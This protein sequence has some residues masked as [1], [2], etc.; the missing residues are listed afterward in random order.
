MKIGLVQ[1]VAEPGDLSAN[2]RRVVEGCRA[3][4]DAG[5]E[6]IA[7]PAWA[8]DGVLPGGL[9][10][11]S[12]FLLQAQ[13]ALRALAAEV[14]LPLILPCHAAPPHAGRAEPSLFLLHEGAVHK[15]ENRSVLPWKGHALYLHVG[16]DWTPPEQG[17]TC[18]CCLHWPTSAWLPGRPAALRTAAAHAADSLGVPVLIAQALG[19]SGGRLMPGGS[20]AAAPR[21]GVMQLPL[22]APTERVWHAGA[23]Y[24]AAPEAE[25]GVELLGAV[26]FYLHSLL[27]QSG[28]AGF[29]IDATGKRAAFAAALAAS[30]VGARRVTALVP[31]DSA[32]PLPFAA[33]TLSLPPHKAAPLPALHGALLSAT[34]EAQDLLLL[35]QS[36]L[37][38]ILL[39]TAPGLAALYGGCAPLGDMPDA[40]ILLLYRA[41]VAELSPAKRALLTAPPAMPPE[42]ERLLYMLAH[43]YSPA[44]LCA[45]YPAASEAELRHMLRRLY[46]T[47]S[48]PHPLPARL[49]LSE[50]SLPLMPPHHRLVE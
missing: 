19:H 39:S 14:R 34:A 28:C 23:R 42:A 25:P 26:R 1:H 18:T 40:S 48:A 11:R 16:R 5:A 24:A 45:L 4:T 37:S 15:L 27:Q 9:R 47:A 2:L 29:A 17:G 31:H 41:L 12:S 8:L 30:A 35:N 43:G 33:R 6:L 32:T 3:C 20:L 7:A 21:K 38:D 10:E 22:F 13:A 49:H 46:R 50:L 44:E 36:S